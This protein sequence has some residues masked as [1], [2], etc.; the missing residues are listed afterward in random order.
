MKLHELG[1]AVHL[2][3][4]AA[5]PSAYIMIPALLVGWVIVTVAFARW[6]EKHLGA[7]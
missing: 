3:V 1:H 5:L 4:S 6:Q 7:P 2:I